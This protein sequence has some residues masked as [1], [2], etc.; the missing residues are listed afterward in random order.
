MKL[1]GFLILFIV[2]ISTFI[3]RT[4]ISAEESTDLSSVSDKKQ[5]K[6]IFYTCTKDKEM[7]WMRISYLSNGKCKTVYSKNGNATEVA[8][9][10]TYDKCEETINN[11]K[12]NLESGGYVC[13]EKTLLGELTAE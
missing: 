3:Y 6:E 13:K 10:A 2:I 9:A 8:Q 7:R 11:V 5:N 4:Q 1:S 12:K